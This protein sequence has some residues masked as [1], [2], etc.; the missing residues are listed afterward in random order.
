MF[1][2]KPLQSTVPAGQAQRPFMQGVPI[3]Q[4]VPQA[5]QLRG[6]V[7]VSTGVPL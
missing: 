1:T 7:S 4:A 5:P 3:A 6:S 2:Q